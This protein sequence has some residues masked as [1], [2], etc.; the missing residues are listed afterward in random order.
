VPVFARGRESRGYKTR[1]IKVK[2]L[3]VRSVVITA[4]VLAHRHQQ[5]VMEVGG[6]N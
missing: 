3:C 6:I 5:L 1:I 2:E 4:L